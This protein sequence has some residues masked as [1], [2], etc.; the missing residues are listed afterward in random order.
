MNTVPAVLVLTSPLQSSAGRQIVSLM[1]LNLS[2]PSDI[3]LL[4]LR[5]RAAAR[6]MCCRPDAMLRSDMIELRRLAEEVTARAV[7][8]LNAPALT[9][10]YASQGRSAYYTGV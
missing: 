4:Y 9:R 5:I 6:D 8:E 2:S 7:A 1:D 3:E 10:Y